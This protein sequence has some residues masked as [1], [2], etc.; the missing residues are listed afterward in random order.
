MATRNKMRPFLRPP[1]RLGRERKIPPCPKARR[2]KGFDNGA[3]RTRTAD[4]L[5]A[6]QG[7]RGPAL[8]VRDHK[9]PATAGVLRRSGSPLDLHETPCQVNSAPISAPTGR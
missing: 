7:T 6:M 8:A 2:E 3:K 4:P 9:I 5:H 1:D